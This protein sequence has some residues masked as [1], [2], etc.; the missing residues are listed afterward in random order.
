MVVA[1]SLQETIIEQ[2]KTN[3]LV[4]IP[5]SQEDYL[6][7]APALPFKVEYHA[8]EIIT[9]G[10]TSYWHETLVSTLIGIFYNLF[11]NRDELNI[12]ASN[13]GV[14]IPK[15]EGGFYMPDAM[16]VKGE[17][18]FK[19]NSKAII[20]NPY[21]IIEI[22]SPATST[23]DVEHKLPEYKHLESL[24]QIIYVSPKKVFVSTYIRSENPNIWL[25]QD[26]QSLDD[27]IVV[28]GVSVSLSDIYK[29]IKFEK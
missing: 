27:A 23:F 9:M 16:V 25:N 3:E 26:F 5:A 15:F 20:T 14:S 17:P 8:N 12:L 29:K 4:S 24:Q 6:S 19:E 10:L 1:N 28:E 11:T 21:I 2:L 18:I 13:S 7:I 22:L